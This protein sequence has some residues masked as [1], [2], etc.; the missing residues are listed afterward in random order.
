MAEVAI[1]DDEKLLVN[2]LKIELSHEGYSVSEFYDAG[3]FI[4]YI[5]SNEPDVVLLDLQ[6][7]DINGLEVLQTIMQAGR[8]IPTII[9]TAHGNIES[10]IQAMKAGA[11][12]YINKPF[13]L[14]EISILIK[15]ALDETK[16]VKE[17]EHHRQRAYKNAR[18]K[19]IIGSS[20]PIREL[21]ETIEKLAKI[22]NTTILLR[23]ES[24]TGKDLLAKVIHNL[25]ARSSK[26]FIEINCASFPEN[27]LESE[28]FGHEKGAFTDA[29]QRKTG[30]VEIADGG[31]LFLDEIGEL[32]LPLQSKLLKFIDIKSFRRIG[33]TSEIRVDVRIIS[34]TNRNL[35]N[36]IK[37]GSFRQDLYYRLNVLPITIPPLR[38]RGADVIKITKHY[39]ESMSKKFGKRQMSLGIKAK[40]AFLAYDWP[41][42]VRELKNFIE[43]LVILSSND[44]IGYSQ[45]PL[46]MKERLA[47]LKSIKN[48]YKN[49][50]L[51]M[52]DILEIFEE[53]LIS[54]ALANAGGIKAEAAKILG[55]SRYSLLRKIKRIYGKDKK[56]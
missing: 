28:L 20:P 24:G 50:S 30:L 29:K 4:T 2:S 47:E 25:S 9:I 7:P 26:Q 19:N 35:E 41:G 22:D 12:D 53:E 37:N 54:N 23:G 48:R 10:A 17:V 38:D 36:S 27:L 49:K 44:V 15:K 1:V 31:T 5:Q 14:D 46:E 56:D 51:C 6:L 42:N 18:L 16:L 11:F 45:L 3:S 43:R 8:Y 32:P 40:T 33:G 55:I 13:E 39:L 34:A 52:N 21:L